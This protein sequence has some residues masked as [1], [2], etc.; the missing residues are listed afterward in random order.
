VNEWKIEF[1]IED[2]VDPYG[3]WTISDLL[4]LVIQE[5]LRNPIN[6]KGLRYLHKHQV[7]AR[8]FLGIY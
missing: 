6:N 4:I 3:K 8:H 5:R 1:Y 2:E 7:G